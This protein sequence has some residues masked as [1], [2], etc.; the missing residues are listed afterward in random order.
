MKS[1]PRG[2]PLLVLVAVIF[3]FMVACGGGGGGSSQP[4]QPRP[5]TI[6]T[7]SVLPGTLQGHG[8]STTLRATGGQGGYHWSIAPQSA[9]ALFVDGLSIDANTGVLSG[10]V[11]FAGTAGFIATVMDSATS[12]QLATKSFTITASTPLTVPPT[13]TVTARQYSSSTMATVNFS[14]GVEPLTWSLQPFCLPPGMKSN[15]GIVPV[16]P[17]S[18]IIAGTPYTV[19]TFPCTVTIQDSFS[20]P[21]V[22]SQVLTINVLPPPLSAPSYSLPVRLLLNRPF[23]GRIVAVGGVQ[24][25]SFALLTAGSLPTGLALD[26]NSGQVR[27]TPTILGYFDST[28]QITDSSTPPQKV[29]AYAGMTIASP[30][31]RN[32]SPATATAISN[33]TFSASISPYIDP[34]NGTPAAGDNDYYKL[35][36]LGGA[37]VHVET[38]TTSITTDTVV[39]IVD[40]NGHQLNTCRQPGDTS[41]NFSSACIND[42]ISSTVLSSAL[43]FRVQGATNVGNPF[44]V[45]VLDWR[46]DARPDMTYALDVSG[47]NTPLTI[48]TALLPANRGS[49]YGFNLLR[50]GGTQPISWS[51]IAGTLPPG[52]N[53]LSSGTFDGVLTTDG[54]YSF[55]VQAIDSG[56]PPQTATAQ[57]TILVVEPSQITI[58]SPLPDACLNQPYI[59]T[60]QESGGAPPFGWGLSGGW[61]GLG[62]NGTTGV[63][64]GVPTASGTFTTVLQLDDATGRMLSTLLTLTIKSCP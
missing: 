22:V 63:F 11:G 57:E 8:Y 42:D 4:T 18:A 45:H 34:P 40:G 41:T 59:F 6:T 52:L 50:A 44:Y 9:T 24:P 23:S 13:Q 47:V 21:E 29:I 3:M 20:P 14:G 5:V 56:N 48:V 31:G 39:E 1:L 27:G 61:P 35:V 12:P 53:V 26:V 16:S 60:M 38:R 62:L 36:S 10:T 25:Y 32:D 30:L 17:Y 2:L 43:D 46:G 55:T 58:P 7:L 33:G 37:T 64:S 49:S 54:T 19:G 28:V 15:V 51:V